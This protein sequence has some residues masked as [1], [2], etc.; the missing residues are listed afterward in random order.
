MSVF[1]NLKQRNFII[2]ERIED[3]PPLHQAN[4]RHT[5]TT[6]E[7]LNNGLFA[8]AGEMLLQRR[9]M[10]IIVEVLAK[11]VAVIEE[12]SLASIHQ[13]INGTAQ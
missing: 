12:E 7:L 1:S 4:E 9:R 2:T 5:L 6:K 3:F 13:S 10:K 8:E 11:L